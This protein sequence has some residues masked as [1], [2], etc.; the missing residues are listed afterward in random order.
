MGG[1]RENALPTE[2]DDIP[3]HTG[4]GGAGVAPARLG[5]DGRAAEEGSSGEGLGSVRHTRR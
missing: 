4:A 1:D 2:P 5:V 3:A